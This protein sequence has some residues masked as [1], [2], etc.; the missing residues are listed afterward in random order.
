[1]NRGARLT[2]F[3]A[4]AAGLG[5]LFVW[6]VAGLPDFGTYHGV[7]GRAIVAAAPVQRHVSE[8]VGAVTFDYRGFDSLG[9]ET[10]LFVAVAGVAVVLRRQ[11]DDLDDPTDTA[12]PS[13]GPSE[14]SEA[15]RVVGVALLAVTAAIGLDIIGHGHLSP[16]GGFQGGVIVA[17][18]FAYLFIGGNAP[19]MRRALPTEVLDPLDGIGL[20]GYVGIGI[21]GLI[22]GT[23]YLDNTLPL[24]TFGRL[25]SGGMIPLLSASVGLEV[26]AG[27]LLVVVEYLEQ[28]MR[29][30]ER[31]TLR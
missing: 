4:A 30:R 5:V 25:T 14:T 10:M 22:A 7:Y 6:G 8:A 9:E 28:M 1:M 12:G 21:V 15:I 17:G 11:R 2:V 13:R 18:A 19:L 24:G 23:A 16:G 29:L 20:A 27:L 3:L 31:R 26:A